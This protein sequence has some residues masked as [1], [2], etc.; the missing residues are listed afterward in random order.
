M[1]VNN[2]G[3]LEG[4]LQKRGNKGVLLSMTWKKRY[5]RETEDG[6]LA[7]SNGANGQIL[8]S[9]D[10]STVS[11][12][13]S[14]SLQHGFQIVTPNRTYLF[15]AANGEEKK[16]WIRELK[17]RCKLLED[18]DDIISTS[19]KISTLLASRKSMESTPNSP[20]KYDYKI[21][22]KKRA[23]SDIETTDR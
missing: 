15:Q 3:R 16:F 20:P 4:Y 12:V 14:N 11:C 8:G 19:P 2:Q 1:S 21:D 10:L 22:N 18:Y 23:L 9:I 6:G 13:D 7:Y 17:Y 5:F